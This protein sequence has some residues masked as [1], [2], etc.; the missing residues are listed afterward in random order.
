MRVQRAR[1][2]VPPRPRRRVDP[3]RS[4]LLAPRG[5]CQTTLLRLLRRAGF[6]EFGARD[7]FNTDLLERKLLKAKIVAPPEKDSDDEPDEAEQARERE[8][9]ARACDIPL[10]RRRRR[11]DRELLL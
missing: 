7:D 2:R 6:D 10:A 9:R 8:R 11:E 4:G 5:C 1:G 3:E